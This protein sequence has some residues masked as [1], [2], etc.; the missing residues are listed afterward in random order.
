LSFLQVCL[1][2]R[3]FDVNTKCISKA[4]TLLLIMIKTI[5]VSFTSYMHTT[6]KLISNILQSQWR[7][8][9]YNPI[10][11]YTMKLRVVHMLLSLPSFLATPF[12]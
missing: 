12:F 2:L 6:C 3:Y 4:I 8:I 7:A 9:I 5:L 11:I 1:V 10:I